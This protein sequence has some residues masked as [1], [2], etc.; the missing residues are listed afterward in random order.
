MQ[1][2]IL[3]VQPST[4]FIPVPNHAYCAIVGAGYVTVDDAFVTSIMY[5]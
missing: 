5:M 3:G 1:P 2:S 4:L